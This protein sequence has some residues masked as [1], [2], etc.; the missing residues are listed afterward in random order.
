MKYIVLIGSLALAA[1]ATGYH[2]YNYAAGG[3]RSTQLDVDVFKIEFLGNEFTDSSI[4]GDYGLLRS[5]EVCLENH[6]PY[7]KL[8]SGEQVENQKGVGLTQGRG[9]YTVKCLKE[10]SDGL[11]RDASITKN[12]LRKKYDL[13]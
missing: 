7:Y 4:A 8:L 6:Y 9:I 11:A 10:K 3:F 2:P 13:H 5:A 1:C 12:S